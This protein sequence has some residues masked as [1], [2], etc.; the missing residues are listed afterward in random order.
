MA[1]SGNHHE[2]IE[3]F[4]R[5]WIIFS[6]ALIAVFVALLLYAVY[7]HGDH[8][9][10]AEARA[11]VD[12][13][14][15]K[16]IFAQP[17]L[18][19]L[20]D[21]RFQLAMIAQAF[22]FQPGE[23]TLPVGEAIDFHFTSRD[24]IHGL[25]VPGTGINV[26]LIPG[27]HVTLSYTFDNPGEYTVVCNQYCGVAHHNMLGKIR[28]VDD[29][30]RIESAEPVVADADDDMGT[31]TDAAW[32]ERG[33]QVYASQCQACHQASGEGLPGAFPPI[34]GHLPSLIAA[35]G[36]RDYVVD[37]VLHGL[38]GPIEVQGQTYRGAMP[39]SCRTKTLRHC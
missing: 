14:L 2:L 9:G 38:A 12:E 26:E 5:G 10:H 39:G 37:M 18:T 13:V 3:R 22:S 24:V 36:G 32:M 7:M 29:Y 33:E 11:P 34:R 28:V 17:G 31:D 15:A 19:E 30:G 35:Q 27:E 21:E 6:G 25:H 1:D 16:D 8:M 20:G 4:E 23:V